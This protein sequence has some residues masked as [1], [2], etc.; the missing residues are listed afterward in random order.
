M[1]LTQKRGNSG[2]FFF[3][4]TQSAEKDANY[5]IKADIG[6]SRPAVLHV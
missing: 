4:V 6:S 2:H 5:Q 1:R 3:F